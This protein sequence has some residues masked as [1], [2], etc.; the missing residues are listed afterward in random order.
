MLQYIVNLSGAWE[1]THPAISQ[2][3]C[4]GMQRHAIKCR[5]RAK[6]LPDRESSR[7]IRM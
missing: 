4:A 3:A 6:N 2:G 1:Y 5:V 7:S